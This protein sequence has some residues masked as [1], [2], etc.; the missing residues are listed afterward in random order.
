MAAMP[1]LAGEDVWRC[2]GFGTR[3]EANVRAL[4]VVLDGEA[5][6]IVARFHDRL[7]AIPQVR[8]V[9]SG[10]PDQLDRLRRVQADW[11][12]GLVNHPLAAERGTP[13]TAAG[14]AHVRAG[15]AQEHVLV[16]LE[17]L[18]QEIRQAVEAAEVAEPADKLSSLHKLLTLQAARLMEAYQ[19]CYATQV[20]SEE[21]SVA[22]ERL[23]RSEH[24]AT[25][26]QAAA[27]LAH[28]IR[29]PLAGISGA[30]QVLRDA[31]EPD[32][33]RR[34]VMREITVQISRLDAAV[35]DLLV[36]ARPPSPQLVPCDLSALVDQ[37]LSVI[38]QAPIMQGIEVRVYP[39]ADAP[40]IMADAGQIEDLM[41]NLLFNA[42]HASP[43]D[44][45][46]MIELSRTADCA[47]VTV[48]DH[49]HGMNQAIRR[50]AFEPFFT[51]RAKGT[52]LGLPICR[53]IVEAH[54]G[55]ID[56]ESR[57]GQG[58]RVTV[59]F[60]VASNRKTFIPTVLPGE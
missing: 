48:V 1:S 49:G 26:G 60:P 30:I 2:I 9:L 16:G 41:M 57:E 19:E 10:G 25:L 17:I 53:R 13:P 32:D 40:V 21:R 47:Q 33:P 45:R 44:G 22:E 18:W 4:A 51:T 39:V 20:R 11:L 28:A 3:D 8:R 55:S 15:V 31:M 12:R 7:L 5:E 14:V 29:N 46:I 54:G 36:Y 43:R 24:L 35:K 56:L 38:R 42:A 27:S 58:T 37:A 6:A 52:G 23:T 59:Q 34:D 50:L